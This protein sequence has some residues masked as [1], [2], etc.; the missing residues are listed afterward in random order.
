MFMKRLKRLKG[1]WNIDLLM[2]MTEK[3]IKARYKGTLFGF[4][5]LLLNPVLQMIVIGAV[6]KYVTKTPINNYF[7]FLFAGLLPWNF[8]SYSTVKNTPIIT[9]ERYLIKKAYFPRGIL[10]FSLIFANLFH[11]I[12]TTIIFIFILL[13]FGLLQAS[14]LLPLAILWLLLLTTG[15][16]LFFAAWNVRF[17]DVN[18]IVQALIPLWFYATPVVYLLSFVPEN[19]RLLFYANPMTG[20]IELFRSSLLGETVTMVTGLWLSVFTTIIIVILGVVSFTKESPYFD[21]WI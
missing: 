18:F 14:F 12:I 5:W 3:E 20:I 19:L 2:A 11:F 21:D 13:W 16:S 6:F 15:L 17:R 10:I 4:L 7:V 1:D 8:F 9:N